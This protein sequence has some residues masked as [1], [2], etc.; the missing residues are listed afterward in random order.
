VA[1]RALGPGPDGRLER[2]AAAAL[3]TLHHPG[4]G[5]APSRPAVHAIELSHRFAPFGFPVHS[6]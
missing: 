5:F 4:G 3:V 6:P 2:P 1:E